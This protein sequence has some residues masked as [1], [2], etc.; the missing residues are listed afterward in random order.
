[1][2]DVEQWKAEGDVDLSRD[3]DQPAIKLKAYP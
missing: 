2:E 3:R 1:M